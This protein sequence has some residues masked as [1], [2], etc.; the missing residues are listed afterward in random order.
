MNILHI[1]SYFRPDFTGEGIYFEKMQKHLLEKGVQTQ[2]LVVRTRKPTEAI[3][4][5]DL[6]GKIT[7]LQPNDEGGLKTSWRLGLWLARNVRRYDAVHMH[8]QVDRYFAAPLVCRLLGVNCF[9]SCTLD[10][11]PD[12]IAEGYDRKWRW[13]ARR[14]VRL[15]TVYIAISPKLYDSSRKTVSEKQTVL[16]PQGVQIPNLIASVRSEE[17]RR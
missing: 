10:D 5:H 16:I 1:F 9:Q 3:S 15:I 13:L 2:I 6:D 4:H 17:R 14:L 11:S 12:E 7:Y 8:C